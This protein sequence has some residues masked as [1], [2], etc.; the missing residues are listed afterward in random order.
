MA[1]LT[2]DMMDYNN[3]PATVSPLSSLTMLYMQLAHSVIPLKKNSKQGTH[4]RWNS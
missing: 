4:H 3:V 1:G 2:G